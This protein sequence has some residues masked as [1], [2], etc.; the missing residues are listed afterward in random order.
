VRFDRARFVSVEDGF[1]IKRPALAPRAVDDE[2]GRALDPSSQSGFGLCDMS[3]VLLTPYPATTPPLLA[4]FLRLRAG[5]EI[6]AQLR[7][8]G[9]I[10]YVLCGRRSSEQAGGE[11]IG[12]SRSYSSVRRS[13]L[14]RVGWPSQIS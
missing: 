4:K 9:E 6:T 13:T 5:E 1:N 8:S 7:A 10:Y 3:D 2:R 12:W 11:T 14:R